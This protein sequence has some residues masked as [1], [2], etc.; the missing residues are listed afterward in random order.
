MLSYGVFTL[1]E[2]ERKRNEK[3]TKAVN[4]VHSLGGEWIKEQF[5]KFIVTFRYGSRLV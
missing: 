1:E 2:T 4:G 3:I 5:F